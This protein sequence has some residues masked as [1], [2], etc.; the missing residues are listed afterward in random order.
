MDVDSGIDTM[1]VDEEPAAPKRKRVRNIPI[2]A[3]ISY[4]IEP[5]INYCS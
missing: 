3:Y 2:V 4:D 1:E 5:S